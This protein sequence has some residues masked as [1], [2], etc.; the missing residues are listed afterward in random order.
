MT[1]IVGIRYMCST[2]NNYDLCQN[3]EAKGVHSEHA[4][5]KIRKAGQAPN[6]IVCQYANTTAA[7]RAEFIAQATEGV[8]AKA[9]VYECDRC[10]KRQRIPHPMY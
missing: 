8:Q 1:P 10:H 9:L 6:K 7:Q 3:C 4:M 2:C 5:L